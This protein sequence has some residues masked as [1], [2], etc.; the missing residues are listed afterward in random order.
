MPFRP[1]PGLIDAL[2]GLTVGAFRWRPAE[3]W[4]MRLEEVTEALRGWVKA[5]L[6]Q[7][8]VMAGLATGNKDVASLLQALTR[9]VEPPSVEDRYGRKVAGEIAAL[10]E[11]Q[12]AWLR[13]K[14]GKGK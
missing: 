3:V 2:H 9:D 8:N 5:T 1:G 6:V 12:A 13:E 10:R 14:R 4:R 11:K 7:A